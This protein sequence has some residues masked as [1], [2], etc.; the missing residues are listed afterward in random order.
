MGIVFGFGLAV[1][2]MNHHIVRAED[3]WGL[4]PKRYASLNGTYFDTRGWTLTEWS[5]HPDLL[6]ALYKND[7]QDLVPGLD[8]RLASLKRLIEQ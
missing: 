2:A 4:V 1:V 8:G 7:R 3:S 6:W 5:E